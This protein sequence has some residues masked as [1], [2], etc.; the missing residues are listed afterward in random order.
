[1]K[2]ATIASTI[3]AIFLGSFAAADPA[4][5]TAKNSDSIATPKPRP[6]N[7]DQEWRRQLALFELRSPQASPTALKVAKMPRKEAYAYF[8][9]RPEEDA[10]FFEAWSLWWDHIYKTTSL[11]GDGPSVNQHVAGKF[12][13]PFDLVGKIKV[14]E[15]QPNE[16]VSLRN[17]FEEFGIKPMHQDAKHSCQFL[18]AHKVVNYWLAKKGKPILTLGQFS[19][20]CARTFP[21]DIAIQGR[22]RKG[23]KTLRPIITGQ[24]IAQQ[25]AEQPHTAGIAMGNIRLSRDLM[26]HFLREGYPLIAAV[27]SNVRGYS[28]HVVVIVGFKTTDGKTQF[29]CLDS[30]YYW[31]D[32]IGMAGE[33]LCIWFD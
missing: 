3:G 23:I 17:Q 22:S 8:Q 31:E 28:H 26:M 5:E 18:A 1:M 12:H 10:Q 20:L 25:V 21:N 14:K 32:R 30:K 27:P 24:L 7:R 11:P 2:T 13:Y 6:L 19:A 4:G 9:N 33:T 29:E 15:P 16:V